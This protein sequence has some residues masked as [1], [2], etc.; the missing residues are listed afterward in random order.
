[1]KSFISQ[2]R[3]FFKNSYTVKKKLMGL[4]IFVYGFNFEQKSS[5]Q[6]M[7]KVFKCSMSVQMRILKYFS[8]QIKGPCSLNKC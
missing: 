2:N 4:H 5:M 6:K 1:M 3:N 8:I 7:S